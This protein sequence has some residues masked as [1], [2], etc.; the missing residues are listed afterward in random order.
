MN[1]FFRP[2]ALGLVFVPAAASASPEDPATVEEL[3]AAV[4]GTYKGV[5]SLKADFVQ[6][7]SSAVSGELKQKGKVQVEAPR[8]ARCGWASRRQPP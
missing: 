6:T 2:I 1:R 4:E 7:V 5:T 3:V 8:K